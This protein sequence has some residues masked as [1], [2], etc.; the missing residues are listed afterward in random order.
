MPGAELVS[1]V[2]C[3]LQGL[4]AK[5]F[6]AFKHQAHVLAANKWKFI[7]LAPLFYDK[8]KTH[9]LFT[10][11][12]FFKNAEA[13]RCVL[14]PCKLWAHMVYVYTCVARL[15]F[16]GCRLF[17]GSWTQMVFQKFAEGKVVYRRLCYE[18][19]TRLLDTV[20]D[21]V[22][23]DWQGGSRGVPG[24]NAQKRQLMTALLQC[25]AEEDSA[26]SATTPVQAVPLASPS[27]P[28][29][30]SPGPAPTSKPVTNTVFVSVTN[31]GFQK[32]VLDGASLDVAGI[33]AWISVYLDGYSGSSPFIKYY[34]MLPSDPEL[35]DEFRPAQEKSPGF[36]EKRF[37]DLWDKRR[38]LA[39]EV[40]RQASALQKAVNARA[41]VLEARRKEKIGQSHGKYVER[42]VSMDSRTAARK[43]TALL[44]AAIEANK[45]NG[46][47][48]QSIETLSRMFQHLRAGKQEEIPV[49]RSKGKNMPPSCMP[50]SSLQGWL[51]IA[52]VS[53]IDAIVAELYA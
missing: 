8:F 41:P 44:Q 6:A 26:R 43:V 51:C 27:P 21:R 24:N 53:D 13:V 15:Q 39:F 16:I 32:L 45:T 33:A 9:Q 18:G 7:Q 50:A 1:Q 49:H 10:D 4:T 31:T 48:P 2:V 37:G 28:P 40:C 11:L 17:E 23:S 46:C 3:E 47:H 12:P 19:A 25:I 36:K 22:G 42:K 14:H 30:T 5:D 38:H 29:P 20:A 35:P 52:S 34:P